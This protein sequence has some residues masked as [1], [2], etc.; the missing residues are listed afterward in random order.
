MEVMCDFMAKFIDSMSDFLTKFRIWYEN[1]NLR[2]E[3][4]AEL[5]GITR[6]HLSKVLNERTQPSIKLLDKM[7]QLMEETK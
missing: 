5:L 6:W 3:E 4:I 1:Q 2:Q 7:A